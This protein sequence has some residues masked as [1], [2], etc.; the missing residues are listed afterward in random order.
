M[1]IPHVVSD[2]NKK[3]IKIKNLLIN[4]IKSYQFKKNNLNFIH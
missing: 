4:K 1:N 3:S 2:K